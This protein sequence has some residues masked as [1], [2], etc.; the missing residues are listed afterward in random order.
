MTFLEALAT[1]RPMRQASWVDIL[2]VPKRRLQKA[3]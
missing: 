1:H 3:N 2:D